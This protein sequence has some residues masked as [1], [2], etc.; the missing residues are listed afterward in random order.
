MS[1]QTL[2]L[3]LGTYE[4]ASVT[5]LMIGSDIEH[6]TPREALTSFRDA[7]IAV[8]KEAIEDDKSDCSQ[9]SKKLASPEDRY[10][11]F[12]GRH[13]KIERDLNEEASSYFRSLWETQYHEFRGWENLVDLGWYVGRI[14]Q[15]RYV[16]MQGF[17]GFLAGWDNVDW[18]KLESTHEITYGDIMA[19]DPECF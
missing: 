8:A 7:L 12:C 19:A 1:Y 3:D 4:S 9:C 17:D 16:R 15:G 13:L 5:T 2:I 11:S 18:D 6:A 10:C 14:G